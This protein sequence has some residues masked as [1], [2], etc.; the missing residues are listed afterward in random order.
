MRTTAIAL[1]LTLAACSSASR[2]VHL[3]GGG[4]FPCFPQ[5]SR[6]ALTPAPYML[7][8]DVRRGDIILFRSERDGKTDSVAWRVIGLPFETVV[9][10]ET[11]VS[12]DGVQLAHV[13][14]G[15][16]VDCSLVREAAESL[17]YC[18]AYGDKPRTGRIKHSEVTV[19]PGHFFVLGD[20]RDASYD[21]RFIGTV[22]FD[23]IMARFDQLE[24]ECPAAAR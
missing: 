14:A 23:A 20:N 13:A 12:I 2:T 21:S 17:T 7:P 1:G 24:C 11:T 6:A 8:S 18:V 15:G 10:D 3:P 22:P 9:V 16:C 5:D 19:P 4:M